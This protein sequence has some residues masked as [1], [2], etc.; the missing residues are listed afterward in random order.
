[1]NMM[2]NNDGAQFVFDQDILE[3]P[4]NWT[5]ENI[6][7]LK[8]RIALVPAQVGSHRFWSGNVTAL[9]TNP[10]FGN[11]ITRT[12]R[13]VLDQFD[14]GRGRNSQIVEILFIE[15]CVQLL[16]PGSGRAAL[17]VP[18]SILNNPGLKYVRDWLLAHTRVLAVVEL[19]VETFLISGREGTGTLTAILVIQRRELNETAAILDGQPLDQYPIFMG[20]VTDVGYDRR[21]KTTYRKEAD[22]TEIAV[23]VPVVNPETGE[24]MRVTRER[25]V[26]NDLPLV[27][28]DYVAFREDLKA[29][30]IAFDGS[31]GVYKKL[32][33]PVGA[34]HVSR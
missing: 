2:M 12:E 24:I 29:G 1:M 10:P 30:R 32:E 31:T 22:G 13:H 28:A 33:K 34:D 19:P 26:A 16:K 6:E 23:E 8:K 14:L 7:N 18:Q 27:V 4:H 3:P 5:A 21:G 15:R 17:V 25:V 20:I 9:C 11:D